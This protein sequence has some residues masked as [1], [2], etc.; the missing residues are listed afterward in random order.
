MFSSLF[1]SSASFSSSLRPF[2]LRITF[3]S[4]V[5]IPLSPPSLPSPSVCLSLFV[6][7][8]LCLSISRVLYSLSPLRQKSFG[9]LFFPNI[10]IPLG[11]SMTFRILINFR[12]SIFIPTSFALFSIFFFYPCLS[13]NAFI[14]YTLNGSF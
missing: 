5:D 3:S 13:K 8:C 7:V 9:E 10:L 6:R 14:D 4:N 2:V 11:S 1:P 12:L